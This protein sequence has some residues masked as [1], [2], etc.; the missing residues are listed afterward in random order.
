MIHSN[1]FHKTETFLLNTLHS[2]THN[3]EK[4]V[5]NQKLC[6]KKLILILIY[7]ELIIRIANSDTIQIFTFS[8][9]ILDQ[10]QIKMRI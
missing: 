7:V 5:K 4:K 6:D 9:R 10:H 2:I 3:F 8:F 1:S